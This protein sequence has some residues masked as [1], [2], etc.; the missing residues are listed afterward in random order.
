[1]LK[2]DFC[3]RRFTFKFLART[4]RETM[5]YKDSWFVRL[6]SGERT[7]IGECP[8]FA[9]LSPESATDYPAILAKVCR[10]ISK[11][12]K[13]DLTDYPSIRFG[14]ET[15]FASLQHHEQGILFPSE[16]TSGNSVIHINGLIWMG[17]A[18]EMRQRV[19][20]KIDTGFHCLKLKIGGVDFQSELDI[21]RTIRGSFSPTALE[22][23]LDANGA[24]TS[25]NA[26]TRLDALSK[27]TI[28]SI[29][30]P[31]KPR[32]YDAMR[33]ICSKSPIAI[34]LDE[35]LIGVNSP[36]DKLK[37][38]E[39]IKPSYAILK[40]ALCGGFGGADEWI[41]A[42][43]NAGCGWW[44]TS[45]LESNIGLNAIAQWVYSKGVVMPQGLGTGMIYSDNI[46]S[47]IFQKSDYIAY[48]PSRNWNFTSL[49]PNTAVYD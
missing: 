26:L 34:A 1:M 12:E 18:D 30:Q 4:S 36:A 40:P 23:R 35:E 20:E 43:E 25:D 22:I 33:D 46:P 49:F 48:D 44:A 11:G 19:T 13:P 6:N 15:A 37:L 42:A 2:A 10:D 31:I 32:Q 39:F 38:L 28:H 5:K 41:A 29:E 47:P 24:F 14:V 7:A 21:L 45:A 8:L 3:R 9:G 27:Y 16:W 17:S